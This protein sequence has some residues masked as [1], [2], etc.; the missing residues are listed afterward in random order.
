MALLHT[1][2]ITWSPG[3]IRDGPDTWHCLTNRGT[4]SVI[5]AQWPQGSPES[6]ML[7]WYYKWLDDPGETYENLPPLIRTRVDALARK[8]EADERVV[9]VEP[10][11][12]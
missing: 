4:S 10:D 9:K 7:F 12:D 6:E 2:K 11:D 8:L 1:H 5:A 3:V